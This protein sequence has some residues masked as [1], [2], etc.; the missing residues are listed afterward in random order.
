MRGTIYFVTLPG[1][2]DVIHS[3][4]QGYRPVVVVSSEVG[5]RTNNIAMV[6]P[7]TTKIKKLSCNVNI[8]WNV[9]GK[10]SQVL[11]NQIMTIPQAYLTRR[12]GKITPTEQRQVDIAMLISLGVKV[13]YEEVPHYEG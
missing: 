12:V 6:C 1:Y 10:Q 4:E 3:C 13:N 11:C 5:N 9:N 2:D 7:I 8:E